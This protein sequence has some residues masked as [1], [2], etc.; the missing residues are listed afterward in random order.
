M[1]LHTIVVHDPVVVVAGVICPV[2]TY[3]VIRP[4]AV[5]E[6]M[7]NIVWV[8]EKSWKVGTEIQYEQ[9]FMNFS[10]VE[11]FYRRCMHLYNAKRQN[12]ITQAR[13]CSFNAEK[14]FQEHFILL[15]Y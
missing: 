4:L 7:E 5:F 1:I 15:T 13:C 12:L 9:W 10:H 8:V 2:R 14:L 3:Q 11:I 6:V